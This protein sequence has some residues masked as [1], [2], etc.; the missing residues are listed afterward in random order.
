M[1]RWAIY[2]TKDLAVSVGEEYKDL[3]KQFANVE[4]ILGQAW[5]PSR[6]VEKVFLDLPVRKH[7]MCK[8]QWY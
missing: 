8:V 6:G 1:E 5:D 7:L 3:V 2:E 4:R